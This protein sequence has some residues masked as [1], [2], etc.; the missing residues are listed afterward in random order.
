M[1]SGAGGPGGLSSRGR[2]VADQTTIETVG[3]DHFYLS[4]S[5]MAASE[6]F[7]DGVMRLLG[8]KKGT[9]PIAGEPHVHY[10]NRTMQITLRPARSGTEHD[11][12]RPGLHH[13][14]MRVMTTEEVD[15]VTTGLRGL[16]IRPSPPRHYPQYDPDYY[17]VFFEDP[18]GI[19]IEVVAEYRRRR[20][21]RDNWDKL[22]EFE[23]PLVKA[24][25]LE[26]D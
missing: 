6:R 24:G 22:D 1:Q 13:F 5:D 9:N 7:Y 12:Y 4:V 18:D 26:K 15:Q 14:C 8:F 3:L 23:D 21:I 11:A 20:L 17:A 19:R 25:L 16:G 2:T 10:Y